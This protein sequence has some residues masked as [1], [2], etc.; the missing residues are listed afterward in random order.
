[1]PDP[2][3]SARRFLEQ[4]AEFETSTRRLGGR[5]L[6]FHNCN[7][8]WQCNQS[9]GLSVIGGTYAYQEG[10]AT[11]GQVLTSAQHQVG[12]VELCLWLRVGPSVPPC[13]R[14]CRR[15]SQVIEKARERQ[16]DTWWCHRLRMNHVVSCPAPPSQSLSRPVDR[17]GMPSTCQKQ[18]LVLHKHLHKPGRAGGQRRGLNGF[19]NT[20]GPWRCRARS[21]KILRGRGC[22]R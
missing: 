14:A 2:S 9:L 1:M 11:R 15:F 8:I 20:H 21:W 6:A 3:N 13:R 18:Y 7:L 19:D 10:T 12:V 22:H 16:T 17:L 5:A 4:L